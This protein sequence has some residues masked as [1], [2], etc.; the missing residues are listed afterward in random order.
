MSDS[1]IDDK[2]LANFTRLVGATVSDLRSGLYRHTEPKT[3]DDT[4]NVVAL[5][6]QALTDLEKGTMLLAVDETKAASDT[7]R[8]E[9]IA[10]VRAEAEAF[11]ARMAAMLDEARASYEE[12]QA[13]ADA[14][15]VAM[16]DHLGA[17]YDAKH[18]KAY[19]AKRE[20][21]IDV[22]MAKVQAQI[23]AALTPDLS[24]HLDPQRN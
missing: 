4:R 24:K 5:I 23:K 14:A 20:E 2:D 13:R 17:A 8:K 10:A 18:K 21:A 7:A 16:R 22:E 3:L 1:T 15:V 11:Q 12:A 19:D 6:S 9:A